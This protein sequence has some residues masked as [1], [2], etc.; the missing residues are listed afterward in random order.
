MIRLYLADVTRAKL[1]QKLC[2]IGVYQTENLMRFIEAAIWRMRTG[3]PWRDLPSYFGSWKS[4]YNRFNVWCQ[5]G[6]WQRIFRSLI[7]D[8]DLEWLF[9]DGSYVK[10]HQ[11]S[12]GSQEPVDQKTTGISRGGMTTKI[13]VAVDSHGN[14]VNFCLSSG[15]VHD[16]TM[17]DR[18]LEE[19]KRS[20]NVICDK[21]YDSVSNRDLVRSTGSKPHIPLRKRSK[22][23]NKEFDQ[24]LYRHRH[25]VENFFARIKHFRAVATRFDKLSRNYHSVIALA[26]M[27]IWLK[28]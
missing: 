28:L 6:L 2:I 12:S 27:L 18:F 15:S 7:Q 10:A 4:V 1:A 23:E 24:E 5:V 25:L 3:L 20:D 13:H 11:H 26:C 8:P 9:V 19:F 22:S 17:F 14:P 21:G 16:T